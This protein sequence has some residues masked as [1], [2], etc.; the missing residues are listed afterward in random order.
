MNK[1]YG[2][3]TRAL[4]EGHIPDKDTLSRAV[5]IYQTTSYIFENSDHAARL[6]SLEEPGNVYT[7]MMNPTTDVL[8]KRIASLENGVGALAVSS[9]Q[10]AITLAILNLCQCGDHIVSYA[11]LY[12]GTYNLFAVTLKKFGIDVS[13][14]KPNL[15]E[16]AK[17]ITDK[18]KCIYVETIGNPK[19][20]IPDIEGL[21]KLAEE[22]GIPLIVDN[23]FAT[24][25]L[26]RPIEYGAHIVIHSATKFIGGHGNSIAGVIVDSGKFNW[27]KEK[28]SE[29]V[30]PDPSYHGISY[31][32]TFGSSAYI[33]KA[34]VQL[35]RDLG[36]CISPFNSFLLLQGI[37]TLH[38]RMKRHSENTRTIAKFLEKH[39]YVSW[40]NYPG[41]ESHPD[42]HRAK[43]YF[44]K[45]CGALLTFGIKGG[46][47]EGKKFIDNLK[48]FSHLANIGDAKS[49]VIHPASTTHQQL[50]SEQ[51]LKS[52]VSDDLIRLSIGL[53]DVDD[54]IEDLDNAI[55]ASQK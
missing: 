11:S 47:E 36:C 14:V 17:A 20:D 25:Y 22:N 29:L 35:L 55:L 51:R 39:P 23:T 33:V 13:L 40:V 50:T 26:F 12:G 16:A 5:P 45:G 10:A 28:F 8:E 18:T 6:F 41:L 54:L 52:G 19:L 32:E 3:N 2:F 4:H 7:R 44:P 53:E 46:L 30:N 15:E 1:K 24:P 31:T 49:L 27:T 34:R 43:K 48:I 38:I 9:G 42:Y 37:E 21:S